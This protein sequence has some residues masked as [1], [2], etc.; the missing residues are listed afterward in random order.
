MNKANMFALKDENSKTRIT[1]EWK[2]LKS[3]D[4]YPTLSPKS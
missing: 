1:L 2:T 4:L 3:K